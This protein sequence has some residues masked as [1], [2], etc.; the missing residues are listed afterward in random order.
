M[1]T[2]VY[3]GTYYQHDG[4]SDE[5]VVYLTNRYHEHDEFGIGPALTS[6]FVTTVRAIYV[7]GLSFNLAY[8]YTQIVELTYDPIIPPPQILY[9]ASFFC[10]NLF[11]NSSIGKSVYMT[12]PLM[13]LTLQICNSLVSLLVVLLDAM[14]VVITTLGRWRFSIQ[15]LFLLSS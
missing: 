15:Q 2:R 12:K 8:V 1:H 14:V 5:G 7:D 13:T 3:A 10:A 6:D 9:A 4:A 11:T